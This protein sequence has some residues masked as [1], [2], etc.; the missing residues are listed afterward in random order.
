[1]CIIVSTELVCVHHLFAVK[2]TSIF[3]WIIIEII[4]DHWYLHVLVGFSRHDEQQH[5][6][7][8]WI[9]HSIYFSWI[10]QRQARHMQSG[11]YWVVWVG[12]V[13][14]MGSHLY[15][16]SILF[17]HSFIMSERESNITNASIN[18]WMSLYWWICMYSLMYVFELSFT[19][20]LLT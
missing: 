14:R 18:L 16:W 11:T 1:M 2:F 5:T 7:Y 6:S 12:R 20:S 15:T 10:E 9:L 4:F 17:Y 13:V 8:E 3:I 19:D